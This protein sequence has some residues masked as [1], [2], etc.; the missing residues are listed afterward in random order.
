MKGCDI[1]FSRV[2]NFLIAFAISIA[3]F[4]FVALFVVDLVV[5][6][7]GG[8]FT[9][10]DYRPNV[11]GPSNNVAD[12]S[13]SGGESLY[14]LA[15]VTDYRPS[16]YGDYDFAYIEKTFGALKGNSFPSDINPIPTSVANLPVKPQTGSVDITGSIPGIIGGLKPKSERI[17][18][19]DIIVL[20]RMDKESKQFTFT[21]FPGNS[22]I[23]YGG[24]SMHLRDVYYYQ[25]MEALINI[26]HS[27]TGIR[28][29]RHLVLHSEYVDEFID[30]IGGIDVVI[31]TQIQVNDVENGIDLV[32]STGG[33]KLNGVAVQQLLLYN[34]YA[35]NAPFSLEQAGLTAVRA[36]IANLT[37]ASGYKNAG[38][39]FTN[40]RKF[41]ITDM[42]VSDITDNKDIWFA[43]STYTKHQLDIRGRYAT[44]DSGEIFIIDK[45]KTLSS[46]VDY[47][48]Q[49]Q[50]ENQAG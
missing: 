13:S 35:P 15:V 33:V 47:R 40:L 46:F 10:G 6:C 31:P 20:V 48:K 39:K 43:Y 49:Y 21:Y 23:D 45:D 12:L 16:F 28:P 9:I 11:Q 41:C 18:H 32:L 17:I 42:L 44:D 7:I 22:P 38:E 25:G 3:A 24:E 37:S 8:A 1:L 29:D 26:V 27:I 4:G 14:F 5:K 30:G 19:T 34:G 50:T 2:K 36:V